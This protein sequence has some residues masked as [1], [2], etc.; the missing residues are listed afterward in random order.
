MHAHRPTDEVA[1]RGH[2]F[3]FTDLG[4][5]TRVDHELEMIPKGVFKLMAPKMRRTGWMNL[6]A[7]AD[8]LKRYLERG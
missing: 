6:R 5:R 8:A 1:R 7:T 4:D 3:T 2:R